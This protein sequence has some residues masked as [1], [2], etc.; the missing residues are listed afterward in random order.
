MAAQVQ[1]A[2]YHEFGD[3]LYSQVGE[4]GNGTPLTVLSAFARLG[5][6][7]WSEAAR[8][9]QLP[10]EAATRELTFLISRLSRSTEFR[11]RH[12]I[13]ARIVDLLPRSAP[14]ASKHTHDYWMTLA[15]WVVLS[16][17]LLMKLLLAVAVLSGWMGGSASPA[18]ES[19][20]SEPFPS[21]PIQLILSTSPSGLDSGIAQLLA[22]RLAGVLGQPV[23]TEAHSGAVAGPL[24]K[25]AEA[26]GHTLLIAQTPEMA[27]DVP[28][29]R[30]ADFD[31]KRD[32][33]PIALVGIAPLA[34]TV[35]TSSPLTSMRDVL[36][37]SRS[38]NVGL[39]LV[40]PEPGTPES[41]AGEIFH[42]RIRINFAEGFGTGGAVDDLLGGR[43]D[44]CFC[45]LPSV[46]PHVAS[47][48]LRILAVSS[49]KRS[50]ALPHVPTLMEDPALRTTDLTHWIGVFAPR[51]TP[52]V[53]AAQ[54][55]SGLNRILGQPNVREQ[56]LS[57]GIDLVPMSVDQFAHFV[58]A[59]RS[60]YA[61]LRR[62]AFCSRTPFVG[63]AAPYSLP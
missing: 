59:E 13:A 34:I 62:E 17:V 38:S 3:F 19:I 52:S 45:S 5:L 55:N 41:F 9:A 27:I 53:I 40:S 44:V 2:R 49:S 11:D 28:D 6:D 42:S 21:R 33:Q 56:L 61:D 4:E 10:K 57:H 60:K 26:D 7:P 58:D 35:P 15:I 36:D 22:E 48:Q 31:P 32:L 16:A 39:A 24:V 30:K 51:G 1:S 18:P 12:T 46:L 14:A 43:A 54:L 23:S 25:Q 63:C 37:V 47:G 20:S 29:F 8:L 50:L